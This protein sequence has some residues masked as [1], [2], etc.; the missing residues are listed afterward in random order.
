MTLSSPGI[1][2][3]KRVTRA[4][5]NPIYFGEVY[6]RPYDSNWTEA[7]PPF[8]HEMLKFCLRERRGVVVLPPEFL[9]TTLISQVLPLWLTVNATVRGQLLRGMLLSEEED[10]AKNN[11]SVVSWHILNNDFLKADF[12]DDRGRPLLYPDADEKTWKD[13]AIIVVRHGTSKDPTWQ[14][15]GIDSKGIQG[16]RLDWLIGDD[17]ITPANAFSPAKRESA[18][19]TWDMQI[20]T[21]LVEAGRALV[22][23]NFNDPHDLVSTLSARTSYASFKRPAVAIKGSPEVAVDPSDPRA[24]P[25]WPQNWPLERLHREKLEKPNRFQRIFLLSATSEQGE[26][27]LVHWMRLIKPQETPL[28]ESKFFLSIDPA[29]GGETDDLDYF[30]IAIGAMHGANLDL[31]ESY[32]VRAPIPQ[33]VELVGQFHDRFQRIGKG[34]IAIG[35]AKIAM[36]RYFRG[37]LT[38]KRPDLEAKLVQVSVPGIKEERLEALGPYAQTGWLRCWDHVWNQLTAGPEDRYQEM[39]LYEEWKAFPLGRHDD[40]LDGLDVLIRTAREFEMVGDMEFNLE[41]LEAG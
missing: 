7:L 15:K 40:R 32:S 5:A 38:I 27:L 10:M 6:V 31:I 21:R 8:A 35:G 28:T 33:Q 18:L 25:L 37:A 2:R 22:A 9:K 19:R 36:D 14:A 3:R 17:L 20:T 29:P 16:R 41:V 39:S 1:E 34:V 24:E 12:S 23:G 4:L 11:L 13:D 30:N 26:K